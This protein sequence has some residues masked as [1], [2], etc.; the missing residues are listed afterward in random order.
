MS[1]TACT[2][3]ALFFE[4]IYNKDCMVISKPLLMDIINSYKNGELSNTEYSMLLSMIKE[5]S[6]IKEN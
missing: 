6:K 2:S 4:V 3:Y 5:K 1:T